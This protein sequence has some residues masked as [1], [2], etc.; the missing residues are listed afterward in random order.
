MWCVHVY[1]HIHIYT[2]SNLYVFIYVCFMGLFTI[3]LFTAFVYVDVL[4]ALFFLL[5]RFFFIV[6]IITVLYLGAGSTGNLDSVLPQLPETFRTVEAK[7]HTDTISE[8]Q[9]Q[10]EPDQKLNSFWDSTLDVEL[11]T[12]HPEAGIPASIRATHPPQRSLLKCAVPKI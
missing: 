5:T 7:T 11:E 4:G 1:I 9:E 2:T 12:G 6:L 8:Q 3:H 10:T